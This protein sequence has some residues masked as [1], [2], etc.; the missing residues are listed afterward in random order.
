MNPK[1]AFANKSIVKGLDAT[2]EF[3]KN[4]S[5]YLNWSPKAKEVHL[6]AD[7]KLLEKADFQVVEYHFP[8]VIT[9]PLVN[10]GDARSSGLIP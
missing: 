1:N 8:P 9:F 5:N 6:T 2:S 4:R 7:F 10:I 3:V